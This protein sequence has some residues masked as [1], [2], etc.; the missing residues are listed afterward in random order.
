M[1]VESFRHDDAARTREQEI[2]NALV[3]S[4][5]TM[6]WAERVLRLF[7]CPDVPEILRRRAAKNKSILASWGR[8]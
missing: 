8:V 5:D 4:I 7:H 6:R 1:D 3:D 2:R